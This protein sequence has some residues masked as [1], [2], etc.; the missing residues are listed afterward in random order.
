[1]TD[2]RDHDDDAPVVPDLAGRLADVEGAPLAGR[3][4]GYAGLH[5]ELRA[6]LERPGDA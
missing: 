6:A 2:A 3:A 4:S 5:D 1:M